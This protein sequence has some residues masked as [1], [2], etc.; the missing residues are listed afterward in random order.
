MYS[1]NR[2][3]IIGYIA[4]PIDL[5]KIPSG[6]SVTDLN[7]VVPYNFVGDKG[8]QLSGKG[9]YTVTVWGSMADVAAQFLKPGSQIFL[10]GRLQTDSWEDQETKEKRS[11]TKIVAMDLIMLDPKDGQLPEPKDAPL[12]TQCFSRAE[13][14]GNVTKDPEMR[15]TTSGKNVLSIGVATNERWREKAT[16]EDKERTEFHN[17]VVWGDLAQQVAQKLKK[18]NRVFVSGR[19]QTRSWETQAGAKRTTTEIVAEQV[20]MLGV[21][22][23]VALAAISAGPAAASAPRGEAESVGN[24]SNFNQAPEPAMSIPAV[25]Y[26]SEVR[27]EDLP[28]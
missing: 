25:Q 12:L 19:V 23:S 3:H 11:K 9:F 13:V 16:G 1:L 5:R 22:N 6:T 26:Q 18:G 15:T 10:G 20:L 17:I 28:F 7:V 21:S 8:E 14:V 4:Q 27:V 24:I 2:V